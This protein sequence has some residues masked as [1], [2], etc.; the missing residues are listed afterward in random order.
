MKIIESF[1]INVESGEYHVDR[2]DGAD[3]D[4]VVQPYNEYKIG[5]DCGK[6]QMSIDEFNDFADVEEVWE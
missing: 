2:V 4:Y 3:Y 1:F 5:T 6:M